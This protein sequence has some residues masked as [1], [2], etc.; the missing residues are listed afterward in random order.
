LFDILVSFCIS[1]LLGSIPTA[2]VVVKKTANLDIRTVGSGNVGGRNALEVTGKNSVGIF[3]IA[4]DALKGALAVIFSY[5]CFPNNVLAVSAAMSGVVVGHCY[6]VWLN[7]KGGRGLATTAG[8][9][10]IIYW[11]WIV[12]W[13]MMYFAVNKIVKNVHRA[14]AIALIGTP[15]VVIL[16]PREMVMN[17]APHFFTF[18]EFLIS[19]SS[20]MLI[21][22]SKHIQPLIDSVNS[23]E[24]IV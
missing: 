7:F 21:C 16:L 4:I 15:I 22:L 9:F 6:P 11:L 19:S 8:V 10:L 18:E 17:Q 3:V 20:L 2:Y 1:Y 23:Q 5:V 24:K 13:L 14:S 12:V